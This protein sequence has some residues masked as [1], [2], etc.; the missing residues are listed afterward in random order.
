MQ[1]KVNVLKFVI[2]IK[3]FCFED[4]VTLRISMYCQ[5]IIYCKKIFTCFVL[6]ASYDPFVVLH[7]GCCLVISN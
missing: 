2:H 5:L 3:E 7:R 6:L 4:Y 1:R